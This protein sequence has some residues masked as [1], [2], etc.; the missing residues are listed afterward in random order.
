MSLQPVIRT[1]PLSTENLIHSLDRVVNLIGIQLGIDQSTITGIDG[2]FYPLPDHRLKVIAR[3]NSVVY[4][5]VTKVDLMPHFDF[6]M[7]RV[8]ADMK[9][10]APKAKV[11]EVAATTGLG[12]DILA[13]WLLAR[14]AD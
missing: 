8:T 13:E 14:R 9:R 3:K 7:D 12:M 5:S 1:L 6:K 11:F 2:A 10:L 4:A